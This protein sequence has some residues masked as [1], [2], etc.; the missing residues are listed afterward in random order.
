M[1]W[2]SHPLAL[3]AT[4]KQ[5]WIDGIAQIEYPYIS[6]KPTTF[7][8][9]PTT[10]NFEKEAKAA[11]EHQGLPPLTSS[12]AKPDTIVF[13]NVSSVYERTWPTIQEV[14]SARD[15]EP[16]VVVVRKGKIACFG[17]RH[18]CFG[19]TSTLDQPFESFNLQGGSISWVFL[20]SNHSIY[21]NVFLSPGLVSYG[22]PLGLEEIQGEQSTHDGVVLDPLSSNIPNLLAGNEVILAVDGLQ[23]AG[24][25]T[26][27]VFIF[28][29]IFEMLRLQ[30][31]DSPIMQA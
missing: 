1:I 24:R 6:E 29:V 21:P 4:P 19:S 3:G 2:D 8:S 5:V 18:A 22:S 26:L 10:P 16:G 11:I 25:D 27:L 9:L 7:Q 15:G 17:S 31:S 20:S 28:D 23:F 13:T 30:Q 14:F 12:R